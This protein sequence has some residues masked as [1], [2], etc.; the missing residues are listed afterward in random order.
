MHFNN[1]HQSILQEGVVNGKIRDPQRPLFWISETETEKIYIRDSDTNKNVQKR[2]WFR[3]LNG[4][5][6]AKIHIIH[7]TI[8][9]PFRTSLRSDSLGGGEGNSSSFSFSLPLE[10]HYAGYFRTD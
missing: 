7:D 10:G 6:V 8:R 9:Q 4:S 5:K 1:D 2:D 3:D